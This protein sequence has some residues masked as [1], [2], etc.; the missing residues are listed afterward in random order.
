MERSWIEKRCGPSLSRRLWIE[1]RHERSLR[2]TMYRTRLPRP[3]NRVDRVYDNF[4]AEV[5]LVFRRIGFLLG[6]FCGQRK[7]RIKRAAG[8]HDAVCGG[9][10]FSG[11]WTHF[12]RV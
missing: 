11:V 7:V 8:Q 12:I 3:R 10:R 6:R 2:K 1:T 5:V 9:V 4:Q